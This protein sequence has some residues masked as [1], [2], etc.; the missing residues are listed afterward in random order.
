MIFEKF[1]LGAL[2]NNNYLLIDE[3]ENGVKEA[4]LIDCSEPCAE[5]DALIEKSG[6]KLKYILLTHGHFDHILGV[7][8][9][10]NK[11]NCQVLLHQADQILVDTMSR[12]IE[13]FDFEPIEIQKIDAYFKEGD[14]IKFGKSQIKVIETPG[15]TKGGVCF[16]IENKIFTGDT[17]FRL[18]VGRTDLM[19]GSF[20]ELV[21]SVKEKIFTL[22][23]EIEVYPGHGW[24]ST[25]GFEKVNNKFL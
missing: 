3:D 16:L 13:H 5:I 6:A 14:I 17:L 11:Y 25:V 8:Y 9:Y 18:A 7:N 24:Q 15:H 10:K 20:S 4:V 21:S 23:D 19:G 2:D 1:G 22:D 12:Y